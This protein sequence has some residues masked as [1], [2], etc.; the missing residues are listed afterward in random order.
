MKNGT[1]FVGR[2]L[3]AAI[4]VTSGLGKLGPG[5]AQTQQYMQSVGMSATAFWLTLGII[6]ELGGGVMLLL[7]LYARTGAAMLILFLVPVTFIFHTDFSDQM[8]M[9]MFMK[10]V[11][12]TGGLVLAAFYGPGGWTV[13][14]LWRRAQL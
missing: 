8:Q 10:N 5:F 2:L 14:R 7:G 13:D 12:M 3:L 1:P 6:L 4:F 11:S 9:I